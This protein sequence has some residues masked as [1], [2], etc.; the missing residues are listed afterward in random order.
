MAINDVAGVR[1]YHH[2]HVRDILRKFLGHYF[3]YIFI[4]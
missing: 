1:V 3:V 2:H 4:H